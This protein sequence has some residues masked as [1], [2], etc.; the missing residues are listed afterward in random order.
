MPSGNCKEMDRPLAMGQVGHI[1][2]VDGQIINNGTGGA[3]KH[4]DG[5]TISNGTGGAYK[6]YRW[7]DH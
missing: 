5:Q 3:Y 4:V 1:K 2:H 7:T 6:T